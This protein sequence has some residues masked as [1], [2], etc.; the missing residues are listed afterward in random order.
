[1]TNAELISR[2][3]FALGNRTSHRGEIL[4][5]ML[6]WVNEAEQSPFLPWFLEKESTGLALT[7]GQDY[8]TLPT[9]FLR[10]LD[11][12]VVLITDEEG[13]EHS[14]VKTPSLK[15]LLSETTTEEI[16]QGYYLSSDRIYVAPRPTEY[17][18]PL[19]FFYYGKSTTIAD[20]SSEVTHW[21][22]YAQNAIVYGTAA[23][24]AAAPMRN[25]ALARQLEK[26]EKQ[27]LDALWRD[28]EA[29]LH[30][31]QVYLIEE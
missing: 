26:M 25:D 3:L 28:T 24:F 29:R 8:V 9:D 10:E 2:V 15:K 6:G 30:S 18:Y 14:L 22:K 31:G 16:P 5:A 20:N 12:G 23:D 19:R 7:I 11:E 17:A 13:V 1:M 4:A 27:A 21:G